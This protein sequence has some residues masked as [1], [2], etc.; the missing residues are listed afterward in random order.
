M[1]VLASMTMPTRRGRLICWWNELT[2][3]G[4]LLVVEQRKVALLQVGDVVAVL[5]SDREDEVDF[6]DAEMKDSGC[7]IGRSLSAR[8]LRG[9]GC[10]SLLR[11]SG[12][13]GRG[14]LRRRGGQGTCACKQQAEYTGAPAT[15]VCRKG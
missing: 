10:G 8:S 14:L 6:V 7:L 2:L 11:R 5:V 3:C 12:G 15:G 9:C 4:R 1:E 13:L